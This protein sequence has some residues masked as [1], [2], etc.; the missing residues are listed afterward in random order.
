MVMGIVDCSYLEIA[1]VVV[2]T[3]ASFSDGRGFFSETFNKRDFIAAGITDDFVQDNHSYSKD[4]GTIRG[5]HFQKPP[6]AQAKLVRVVKGRIWDVAVD[7]RHGSITYGQWVGAEISADNQRQ[8]YIPVGFA[9]GF[10]TMEP[11]TEVVYK[12]SNYY[13]PDHDAGIIWEDPDLDIDW[14][15]EQ[16]SPVLSQKDSVLPPLK[17][18]PKVFTFTE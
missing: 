1:G 15:I 16:S 6:F 3:P 11:D 7:I 10:A 2:V 8:I 4:T 12:V 18:L 14:Q 9:H 5:L 17:D 13:A